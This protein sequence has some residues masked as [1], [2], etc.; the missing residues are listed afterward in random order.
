M[1]LERL[2]AIV[3]KLRSGNLAGGELPLI[4]R[5]IHSPLAELLV[6]ISP[7]KA[8]DMILELLRSLIPP[9]A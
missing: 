6:G 8:D 2:L 5:L 9:P 7:N 3:E 1:F 4:R